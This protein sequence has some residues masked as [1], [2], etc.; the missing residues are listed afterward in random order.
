MGDGAIAHCGTQRPDSEDTMDQQMMT[1]R[2]DVDHKYIQAGDG[3]EYM[4]TSLGPDEG[5][6]RL[7]YFLKWSSKVCPWAVTV[8]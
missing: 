3:W 7:Q 2:F 1:D 4:D 5:F 6:Q 8:A